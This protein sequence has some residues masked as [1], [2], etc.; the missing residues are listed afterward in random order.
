MKNYTIT[1]NNK[2]YPLIARNNNEAIKLAGSF[3]KNI[4][5]GAASLIDENGNR[6]I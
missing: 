2:T 4:D 3:A 5:N 6:I 1:I